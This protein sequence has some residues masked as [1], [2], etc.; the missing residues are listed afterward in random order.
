MVLWK[1]RYPFQKLTLFPTE[2]P[3]HRLVRA[4]ALKRFW[5]VS[6]MGDSLE[7][8]QLSPDYSLRLPGISVCRPPY[9]PFEIVHLSVSLSFNPIEVV[10]IISGS[11]FLL[12]Y[13]DWYKYIKEFPFYIPAWISVFEEQTGHLTD[14]SCL[15]TEGILFLILFGILTRAIN[16][17]P[18]SLVRF[19]L[20]GKEHPLPPLPPLFPNNLLLCWE[21]G[22][23][24]WY[25]FQKI[26]PS[27]ITSIVIMMY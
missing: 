2:K 7:C 19:C 5:F 25:P 21:D 23:Y 8:I 13:R 12:Y 18:H 26:Y 17:I 27:Y 4:W 1:A 3:C 22:M 16:L 10:V 9:L 15:C 20:L 6:V 11:L 24:R 14:R